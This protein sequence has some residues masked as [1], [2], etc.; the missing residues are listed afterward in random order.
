[1][2]CICMYEEF[3]NAQERIKFID[4]ILLFITLSKIPL[5]TSLIRNIGLYTKQ[6]RIGTIFLLRIYNFILKLF[7]PLNFAKGHKIMLK[8]CKSA[9]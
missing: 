9:G 5:W 7:N 6:F 2:K 1:M 4:L 8:I 3:K